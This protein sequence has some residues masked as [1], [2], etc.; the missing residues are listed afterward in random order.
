MFLVTN[1]LAVSP[2]WEEELERRFA[3]R[4]EQIEH[5][6]GFVQLDVMRPVRRRKNRQTGEMEETA[7]PGV[8]LIQTWWQDEAAFWKWTE[9]ESFRAAH[10]NS[11]TPEMYAAPG[12][13]EIHERVGGS[14]LDD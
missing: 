5:E 13:L 14:D 8:Y 11:P 6:P 12:Q 3:E 7:G 9:S 10:K 4:A 2:G 1:R